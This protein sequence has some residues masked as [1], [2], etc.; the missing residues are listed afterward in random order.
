M[1]FLN[2]KAKLMRLKKTKWEGLLFKTLS[3]LH[4]K[5]KSQVPIIC[6]EQYGYIMDFLL[7]DYNIFIEVNSRQYHS[8]PQQVKDDN[9]R[10]RRIQKEGY[11]PLVLTNKQ[12]SIYSK[13]QIDDIIRMKIELI[14]LKQNG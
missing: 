8:T 6:R 10:S 14:K 5:F 13:E 1:Q 11:Y 12:I 3:D 7:T 4:Y 9:R 2:R